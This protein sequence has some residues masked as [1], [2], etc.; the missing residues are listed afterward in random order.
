MLSEG[1][2]QLEY[3]ALLAQ[4]RGDALERLRAQNAWA[5]ELPKDTLK[6][7][8]GRAAKRAASRDGPGNE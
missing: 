5:R 2:A 7:K 3:A 1:E 8:L 4:H 6:R